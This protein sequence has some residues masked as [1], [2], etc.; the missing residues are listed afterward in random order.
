MTP[1]GRFSGRIV[2]TE[3]YPVGDSA[4]HAFRVETRPMPHYFLAGPRL[5]I[6]HLRFVVHVERDQRGGRS[7]GGSPL[8][9]P[10]TTRGNRSDATL[11]RRGRPARFSPGARP[12]SAGD[13]D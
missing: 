1:D 2:E 7:R 4:G 13:A 11:P 9:C 10:R 3:A 6:L 8:A 5:R 12:A